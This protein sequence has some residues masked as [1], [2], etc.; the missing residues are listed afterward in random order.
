MLGRS[1]EGWY[2]TVEEDIS[3]EDLLQ[4]INIT[5]VAE[6]PERRGPFGGR[7]A[8]VRDDGTFFECRLSMDAVGSLQEDWMAFASLGK[9]NKRIIIDALG[10]MDRTR[11]RFVK[12]VKKDFDSVYGSEGEDEVVEL[13]IEDILDFVSKEGE[14]ENSK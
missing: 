2:V 6:V 13:D 8:F 1:L 14:M 5:K 3:F 4:R 10:E 7:T 9:E 12:L 11:M